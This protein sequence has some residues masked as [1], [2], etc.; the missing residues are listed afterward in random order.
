MWRWY[1]VVS[2]MISDA[3][4]CLILERGLRVNLLLILFPF[5]LVENEIQSGE[6]TCLRAHGQKIRIYI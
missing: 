6:M 5:I 1:I 4:S 3:L 2:K